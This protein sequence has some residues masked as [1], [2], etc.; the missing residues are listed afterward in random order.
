MTLYVD[1]TR[2][3]P[4]TDPHNRQ[5]T[6]G[7]GCFIEQ[8][9][10]AASIQNYRLDVSL[11]PEGSDA[12]ALD[13]RPVAVVRFERDPTIGADPLFAQILRRRSLKEPFDLTK[14]VPWEVLGA[15]GASVRHGTLAGSS[16]DPSVV[17]TLR[18][19]THAALD[20]EINT[21]RTYRESVD[22]L[23]IGKAEIEASPD[24]IDLGGPLFDGLAALGQLS[25]EQAL[26]TTSTAFA[27]GRAALL[28]NT[29]TA[30][31]HIWLTTSGNSRVEQ[32][33]AGR[34]WARINLTATALGTGLQPLSQALQEFPEMDEHYR[35]VHKMLSPEGGT[36]QMLGRL[37]YAGT[38]EPSPRWPLDAKII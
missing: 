28:A 29:D 30:M 27:Q 35:Q 2:L 20:L 34:D 24:G 7:L 5:I 12:Q 6:I 38:V 15:L 14:P 25:R 36:V 3:L 1:T 26:D 16:N 18:E 37:G 19:M 13:A 10:I 21:Q 23:R 17:A 32:I 33:A 4:E 8:M 9:A 22:L 11:F 31:A